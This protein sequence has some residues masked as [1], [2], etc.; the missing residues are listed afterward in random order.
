MNGGVHKFLTQE[1]VGGR[2]VKAS[3]SMLIGRCEGFWKKFCCWEAGVGS[4]LY[5]K[6]NAM[7]SISAEG[8]LAM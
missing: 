7:S 3:I 2:Q 6:L 1:E 8:I 4:Q 5:N